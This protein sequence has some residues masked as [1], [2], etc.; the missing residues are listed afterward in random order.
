[1]SW[2]ELEKPAGYVSIWRE[3]SP[4]VIRA[5]RQ[6]ELAAIAEYRARKVQA[7][8]DWADPEKREAMKKEAEEQQKSSREELAGKYI[9]D[10]RVR[11]VKGDTFIGKPLQMSAPYTKVVPKQTWWQRLLAWFDV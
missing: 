6:A 3:L 8:K 7:Y 11:T 1:M 10:Y 2:R 9:D 4:E 5:Q